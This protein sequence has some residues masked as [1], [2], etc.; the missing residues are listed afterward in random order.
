MSTVSDR[1]SSFL[2]ERYL[3]ECEKRYS[4]AREAYDLW[5]VK[6][7]FSG[8]GDDFNAISL[9]DGTDM[10]EIVE[11]CNKTLDCKPKFRHELYSAETIKKAGPA[12]KK[13][14]L[15]HN[16]LTKEILFSSK[17][18]AF[19]TKWCKHFSTVKF[20][21]ATLYEKIKSNKR[22]TVFLRLVDNGFNKTWEDLH[23]T[24]R[25]V[26]EDTGYE[27]PQFKSKTEFVVYHYL[28]FLNMTDYFCKGAF[29]KRSEFHVYDD[30]DGTIVGKSGSLEYEKQ[31]YGQ[32]GVQRHWAYIEIDP[33][34]DSAIFIGYS[35]KS[36]MEEILKEESRSLSLPDGIRPYVGYRDHR[37]VDGYLWR[38][39]SYRA[40][41]QI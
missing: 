12:G 4:Q 18:L 9:V 3:T 15:E 38:K 8:T 39:D 10:L 30:A 7:G 22:V 36:Q 24:A 33:Y 13:Y 28:Q 25:L 20:S 2:A 17:L 34:A 41:D 11:S 23:C 37:I 21:F 1:P 19:A 35:Y 26:F 27:S 31:R 32:I 5:D 16:R 14:L 29:R 40:T 6:N